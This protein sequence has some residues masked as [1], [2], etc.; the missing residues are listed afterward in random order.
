[1]GTGRTTTEGSPTI[2]APAGAGAL[3]VVVADDD[4]AARLIFSE[5]IRRG[6]D[7]EVIEVESGAEAIEECKRHPAPHLLLLDWEMP[8]ASGP[9]VCRWV[10]SQGCGEQPYLLLASVRNRRSDVLE[11]L[12]SGADELLSKPVPP[13]LLLARV[14]LARRRLFSTGASARVVMQALVDAQ[15]ERDG[16]LVVRD[17][18][19]SAR[20]Y[21]CGG[22][23]G[24]LHAS[25]ES[26][27]LV[28]ILGSTPAID[29]E[30]A[31]EVVAE[32]RR[33]HS[34]LVDVLIDRGLVERARLRECLQSWFSRKLSFL[35][36]LP[37]PQTL[38]LPKR[39]RYSED[40]L[41]SLEE[42]GVG[43]ELSGVTPSMPPPPVS[44]FPRTWSQAFLQDED[45]SNHLS[46]LVARC[47]SAEGIVAT[48]VVDRLTGR[49]LASNGELMNPDIAWATIQNASLVETHESVEYSAIVTATSFHLLYTVDPST[50]RLVY[51][52]FDRSR[53]SLAAAR[54]NLKSA[55]QPA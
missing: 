3:R 9:E 14:E 49:S 35:L 11:G 46:E 42:L 51:A 4:P 44:A 7:A 16:E 22:Q 23:V 10:R 18:D 50:N 52:A 2:P 39:L 15:T 43:P 54:L 45:P 29:S 30:T 53:T 6:A 31:R 28:D 27:S 25:D 26:Y 34:K 55:L 33:R 5:T 17:A 36:Q 12:A 8:G 40:L 13:D 21:F 38:F 48:A 1:M 32:C 41:F 24:W 20:V 37:H 47:M 19:I